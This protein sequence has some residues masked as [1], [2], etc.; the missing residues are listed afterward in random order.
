[1]C[2]SYEIYISFCL[3]HGLSSNT[4]D[5]EVDFIA[6][7]SKELIG[8]KLANEE[9]QPL[10]KYSVMTEASKRFLSTPK[11]QEDLPDEAKRPNHK[12]LGKLLLH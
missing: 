4:G 6:D 3:C 2:S 7:S 8:D 10:T 5:V 1:V 11:G 9:Q 12:L